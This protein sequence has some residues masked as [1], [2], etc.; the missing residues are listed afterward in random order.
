MSI[1]VALDLETTGLDSKKDAI[2]EIG[3]IRF[4]KNRVE[5]EYSQLIN[6]GRQIPS[7]I[8]QLTGITNAMVRNAP[9]IEE[10]LDELEQFVGDVPVLGHNVKFDLSFVRQQGLFKY[11]DGLDTYDMASVLLPA[12][13]RYNLAALGQILGIPF[14]ATHRALDDAKVTQ[15]VYE[16]LYERALNLPIDMLAEIVK[17][18]ETIEWGAGRVFSQALK[19]KTNGD[20]G[21]KPKG[22]YPL[23]GPWASI[24]TSD[25]I[26]PLNP[27]EEPTHLDVDEVAAMLEH[28]G[29]FSKHFP[30]FEYRAEQVDMTRVV[31][32]SISAGLHMLVEAGTGTGKSVAYIVP[33]ALWALQNQTRVVISTNTINLQDQLINK[34]IPDVQAV[35]EANLRAAVLKGRRNYLCPRRLE[36]LRKKKPENADE[37]RVMA[38]MLI[39]LQNSKGGD[40]SEINI[41][42]PAERSVWARISAEDEGCNTEMC[43]RRMGGICPF[44]QAR[45]A[46]QSAHIIV[47]NHALLL[48][49]VA[50]GNRI[51]PDY[52]Y[53][54]VDEAHHIESAT[55][56]ALSFRVT[57][58]EVERTLRELGGKNAGIL[59]R[60]LTV[61]KNLLDPGMLGAVSKMVEDLTDKSFQFQNQ[62]KH[63]F[64]A[65]DQFLTEQRDGRQLGTYSQ[66]VRIVSSTR[67]QPEWLSIELGWEETQLSMA[68]VTELLE[69]LSKALGELA[70]DGAEEVEDLMSNLGSIYRRVAEINENINAMVFEPS[71][72]QIYWVEINPQYKQLSIQAVPLHIGSLMEKYLWHEKL[73]VILTSATLTAAGDFDYIR[74]RLN[75]FDADE[76]SVGSP[77]DYENSALLYLPDNIPEPSD[78]NGHQRAIENSLIALCT[79][80]GGKAM[81]LFTSYAQ[82]KSTSKRISPILAEKGIQ[83]YQQ[84]EGA[85]AHM[86]LETFKNSESALLLG[87]RA[88]WEGVDVPGDALS[89]LAIIKIPFDVP[90]DPIIAARSETF[91]NPFYEYSIP[92]AILRFRQGFGRLIRTQHDRGVVAILDRRLLS[93]QYGKM[94]IDSLPE[95]TVITGRI[96]DLPSEAVKWLGI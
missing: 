53:L 28:G 57:Q 37:M 48:A 71:D 2:I 79:A 38:K 83:V 94:F 21:D 23:T 35:L 6:P 22:H 18:G 45:Q 96:E 80:T 46:A 92:E 47:V 11:N 58:T 76:L 93:K 39:W 62:L 90:S 4:S 10:V 91:E 74:N 25:A 77:F 15:L 59:G 27:V 60:I 34:D 84:G 7:F 30:K 12:A 61:A 8:T 40:L 78:R 29:V 64:T 72:M 36:A 20:A 13:G 89:V 24:G 75:A 88:F 81:A 66:Q 69:R 50:T 85:S 68:P 41:T 70:E 55:T 56:N 49:D 26:E 17:M 14:P 63:F 51:L 65:I 3:A 43:V 87:T 52:E 9:R 86:L 82:L 42:G 19:E 33:A 32:K 44:H 5:A 1:I 31:T 67:A 95:C 73:S 16:Q 54:I